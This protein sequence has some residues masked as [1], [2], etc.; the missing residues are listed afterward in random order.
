M[1]FATFAIVAISFIVTFLF[2]PLI[3]AEKARLSWNINL[4]NK[5]LA[6]IIVSGY[7]YSVIK[8]RF[9][10]LTNFETEHTHF[11]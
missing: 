4:I 11:L 5:V 7:N 9:R 2:I 10:K 3:I 8:N 6:N 1:L